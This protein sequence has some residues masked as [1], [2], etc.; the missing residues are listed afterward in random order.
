MFLSYFHPS[1]V[2]VARDF[3]AAKESENEQKIQ[4]YQFCLAWSRERE[5]ERVLFYAST[6]RVWAY[7]G[8]L[9]SGMSLRLQGVYL[10]A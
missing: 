4:R 9:R 2:K 10:A 5:R 3:A 7:G 8:H 6:A 1:H